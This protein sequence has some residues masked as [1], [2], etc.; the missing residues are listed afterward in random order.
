MSKASALN[1][2]EAWLV[3]HLKARRHS[4][5]FTISIHIF[6]SVAP[7]FTNIIGNNDIIAN[8]VNKVRL[9]CRTD[10]ARP[11][12]TI[13]W[14]RNGQLVT[15]S[16][17]VRHEAGDYGGQVTIQELEF[18][19]RR[20]TDGQIV[21]CRVSNGLQSGV[22]VAFTLNMRCKRTLQIHTIKW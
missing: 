22:T 7:R 1:M 13:T 11:P 9:T 10:S 18:E 4:V 21:E 15:S 16:S 14:Y 17:A 20:E 19:A 3:G 5:V 12:S 2:F 8:G 6:V